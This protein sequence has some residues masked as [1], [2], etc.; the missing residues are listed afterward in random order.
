MFE[1]NDSELVNK[2][3]EIRRKNLNRFRKDFKE[4][5]VKYWL[6]KDRFLNKIGTSLVVILATRGCNWALSSGGGCSMCGYIYDSPLTIPDSDS[7]IKQ[8]DL[9]CKASIPV[10]DSLA[11]KIFTSGSFFLMRGKSRNPHKKQ[12]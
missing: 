11:I 8:F 2:I 5:P 6:E 10:K 12:F 3:I 4:K 9:A 1:A 7:L